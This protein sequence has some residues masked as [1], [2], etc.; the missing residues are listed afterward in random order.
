MGPEP[1]RL[2]FLIIKEFAY[3]RSVKGGTRLHCFCNENTRQELNLFAITENT[4]S[5]RKLWGEH[6]LGMDGLRIVKV[7]FK[8]NSKGRRDVEHARKRLVL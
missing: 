3:L 6:L 1:K 7:A 2:H 5:Y 4:D 8:Y